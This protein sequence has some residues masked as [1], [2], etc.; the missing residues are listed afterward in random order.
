LEQQAELAQNI[1]AI[2]L[3]DTSTGSVQAQRIKS[4]GSKFLFV[5]KS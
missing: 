4:Q 1:F 5:R 3:L 2:L